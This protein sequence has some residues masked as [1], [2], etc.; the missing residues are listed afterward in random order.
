MVAVWYR[1]AR[2]SR[3]RSR[4]GFLGAD[5]CRTGG[6]PGPARA[7]GQ[8]LTTTVSRQAALAIA[9]LAIADIIDEPTIFEGVEPP[10]CHPTRRASVV[11]ALMR[12]RA[13][14]RDGRPASGDRRTV[15]GVGDER[16]GS[17]AGTVFVGPDATAARLDA[18]MARPGAAERVAKIRTRMAAADSG[19]N[20]EREAT[21]LR[22]G[23]ATVTRKT[24]TY[25]VSRDGKFWLIHVPEIDGMTQARFLG[26]IDFMVRDLISI[27]IE[28]PT[29]SF[30]VKLGTMT[31]PGT[32]DDHLNTAL[33]LW[34]GA[35]LEAGRA[36]QELRD[37]GVNIVDSGRILGVSRVIARKLLVNADGVDKV[38]ALADHVPDPSKRPHA[39]AEID[40]AADAFV[41]AVAVHR[42]RPLMSRPGMAGRVAK[43]R[44]QMAAA[45]AVDDAD[46][47]PR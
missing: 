38:R 42:W 28:Q 37:A 16:D 32:V 31:L 11:A 40:A 15:N 1:T 13:Q 20:D 29:E 30:D 3:R 47:D 27:W 14:G 26:E 35:D 22:M 6:V 21:A 17:E 36:A 7:P 5:A 4:E 19:G 33:M 18:L 23:G 24:Y 8:H 41:D 44:A 34:L 9:A 2:S 45:E 12:G 25:N 39:D 46:V 43:I 10:A